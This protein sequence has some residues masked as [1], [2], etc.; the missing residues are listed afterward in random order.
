MSALIC[1]YNVINS[2]GLGN[3]ALWEGLVSGRTAISECDRLCTDHFL[4]GKAGTIVSIDPGKDESL[5]MQMLRMLFEH[6]DLH[7][8]RDTFLMVA[9]TVGEIDLLERAVLNQQ[10]DARDSNISRLPAKVAE[11]LGTDRNGMVVSSACASSTAALLRALALIENG[12][13]SCVLVVGVDAVSEFVFSGFSSLMAL[14]KTFARPFDCDRAGLNIGE[15]S[16]YMLLMSEERAKKENATADAVLAGAGMASDANHM[17]GPARDGGGLAKAIEKA[18][19][20]SGTDRESIGFVAAH[21][22]GTDYNDSMEM[23]AFKRV[24]E[25]PRPIFSVKGGIGHTMGSTGLM[26]CSAALQALGHKSVP[27]T[28]GLT[29]VCDEAQGWASSQSQKTET[30]SCVVVNAGFG[31]TN[32]AVIIGC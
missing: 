26:Q 19:V 5:V 17:T 27:P 12:E 4:T 20:S 11:L 16:A 30:S 18:I 1:D 7:V 32:A 21:G 13:E 6:A 8:P 29:H 25:T 14:D 28:I 15:G 9:T 22:T 23:K 3:E 24:F 31:G 10:G 2:Y